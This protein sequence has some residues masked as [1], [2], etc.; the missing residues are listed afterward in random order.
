MA[1]SD[2]EAPRGSAPLA[3]A[4]DKNRQVAE[5]VKEAAEELAVAHAVLDTEIPE[6]A[7]PQE[8]ARAVAQTS[9]LE[10][11]LSESGKVLDEV[12]ETLEREARAAKP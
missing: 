6:D 2:T 11:R 3:D 8:V 1:S 12:N 4:L 10:K 7:R 5:E 9:E